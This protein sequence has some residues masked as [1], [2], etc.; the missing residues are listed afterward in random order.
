MNPETDA[1][2]I[3]SPL[4]HIVDCL[5]A[6]FERRRY[7]RAYLVWTSLLD[8]RLRKRLDSTRSAQEQIANFRILPV[9]YFPRE[10]H[11]ITFRDPWSFPI[12]FH[13][14]C[15]DLVRDHMQ[16]LSQKVRA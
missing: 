9:D 16:N 5:M 7:R 1:L 15:N 11:L 10:S 2:Y 14:S 13:P 8:A 3:L 12:L 6:D 4:P